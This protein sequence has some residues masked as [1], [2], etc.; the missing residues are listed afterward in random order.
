MMSETLTQSEVLLTAKE[1][2][3]AL[4]SVRGRPVP[5]R[6]LQ[7]WRS[8]LVAGRA[9]DIPL[10]DHLILSGEDWYSFRQQTHLWEEL[11]QED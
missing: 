9:L 10:I 5:P 7:Y 6:T 11:P 3:E 8:L 2:R 1:L 4:S